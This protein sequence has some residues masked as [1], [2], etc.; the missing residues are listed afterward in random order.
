MFTRGLSDLLLFPVEGHL[1]FRQG[2][3][4]ASSEIRDPTDG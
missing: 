4:N 2:K 1:D 3:P